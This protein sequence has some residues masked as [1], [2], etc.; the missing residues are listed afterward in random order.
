MRHELL[1]Q[2]YVSTMYLARCLVI[3]MRLYPIVT[4]GEN[5]FNARELAVN[6]MFYY[7]KHIECY[8]LL[9]GLYPCC[10]FMGYF[11]KEIIA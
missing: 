7:C 8:C 10:V 3:S 4:H 11:Y 2:T 9:L 6:N 5:L 1:I